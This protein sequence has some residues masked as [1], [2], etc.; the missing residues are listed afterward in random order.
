MVLLAITNDASSPLALRGDHVL[1]IAVEKETLVA[2]K[3][4]LKQPG[5]ALAAHRPMD[6]R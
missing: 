4:Y 1:S 3:T 6:R 2:C 5:V